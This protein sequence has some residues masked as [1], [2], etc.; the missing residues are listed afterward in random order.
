VLVKD[1]KIL[2]KLMTI[3]GI[4]Q[5][6]LAAA[7]GWRSHSYLGRLLRGD[8][9]SLESEPAQRIARRLGVDVTD[10]FRA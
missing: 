3:E 1:P 7:A 4:S 9:Q 6:E 10:L 2:S 5:R 8:A